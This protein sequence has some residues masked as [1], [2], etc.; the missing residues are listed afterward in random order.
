MIKLFSAYHFMSQMKR[1]GNYNMKKYCPFCDKEHEISII[2]RES[3][4]LIKGDEI[5]SI[6]KVY[7]CE[8]TGLEFSDGELMDNNLQ[9]ARNAYRIKNNLLTSDEIK[10]IRDKYSL[11][12]SD[13]ALILGWGEVTITRYETKEIQNANYDLV[14]RKI[15]DNP[16]MLYDYYLININNFP[17]KKQQK[18][19]KKIISVAPSIEQADSLIENTL[20]KKY[21]SIKEEITGG[22]KINLSKINAIINRILEHGI[23]LY[24]TKFAK[25]LWYID[26]NYYQK[27][28]KSMT[29]LAYLHMNYG[30]CPLG[31]DLIL[32]SKNIKIEE[33][34]DE[35]A[36]IYKIIEAHSDY[37][38]DEKERESIDFI[39]EKFKNYS[40]KE[41]V[42][43]MH[44]EKAYLNTK[45]NEFIS[46]K[47]AN[48]I[49]F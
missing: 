35:E 12:Q 40:S 33:T 43:Y 41:I 15:K 45:E 29:G 25:L 32:D 26:N 19:A 5:L 48:D 16:Y 46:Y 30:A 10:E 42:S 20:E 49:K 23:E 38:L 24:K 37:K 27:T 22:V 9:C 36:N 34:E 17:P 21:F 47:Y 1:K 44:E 14:L 3:K 2:E 11:S 6:E 13:L 8:E 39:V 28:K 31:L 18:I 7:H 4:N